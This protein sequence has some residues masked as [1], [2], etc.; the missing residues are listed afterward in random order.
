MRETSK[1]CTGSL[2]EAV[3]GFVKFAH[4]IWMDRIYKSLGLFH[5][6]LFIKHT[7]QEGIGNIQLL[8]CPIEVSCKSQN[9]AYI[10]RFD[11]RTKGVMIVNNT[12]LIKPLGDESSLELFYTAIWFL[13][14]FKNP[15]VAN[16]IVVHRP[17][18]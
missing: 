8:K 14:Y 16:H 10:S 7:M 11:N 17:G 18:S 2:L 15:L 4:V 3:D 13:L 9:K 12:Q 1:P 6:D 5:V